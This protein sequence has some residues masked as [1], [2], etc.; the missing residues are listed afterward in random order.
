MKKIPQEWALMLAELHNKVME[1][2][3]T[4]D[5][6]KSD[7]YSGE[8]DEETAPLLK[9]FDLDELEREVES[10]CDKLDDL[11]AE[12]SEL[13]CEYNDYDSTE[14]PKAKFTITFTSYI[15]YLGDPRAPDL[16]REV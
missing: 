16:L 5:T 1:L 13:D 9:G 2:Q 4:F 10:I 12:T 8:A 11:E 7:L 15:R 14:E 6:I 3:D